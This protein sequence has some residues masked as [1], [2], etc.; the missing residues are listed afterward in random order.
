MVHG[1]I[2]LRSSL[3][4]SI[5]LFFTAF[6]ICAP[7]LA[8]TCT[9]D[10]LN[11]ILERNVLTVGLKADYKPWGFKSDEGEIIGM[12]ADLALE[13]ANTLGVA[14]QTVEVT[15][16]D[17]IQKLS[18][19]EIDLLIA[20]MSDRA[21]RRELVGIALPNYY[22][23]GTNVMTAQNTKISQWTELK[24]KKVCGKQGAFYNKMVQQRYGAE[25]LS[26]SSVE[27]AKHALRDNECVAWVYDDSSIMSDL[28]SG[29]WEGFKMPLISEDNNPWG[30]AVPLEDKDCILG[31]V[32][33]GLQFNW[34]AN[35]KLIEIEKKWGIQATEFLKTQHARF[36]DWLTD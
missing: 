25:I 14:L 35:G 10:T 16:A 8:A 7:S 22:T 21:D 12:E 4:S 3:F 33:S 29:D 24:D 11:R 15:S 17:R 2:R 9:N 5:I 1:R 13:I 6:V 31:Q 19:G 26:F 23:S 34:H 18:N 30:I 36:S 27:E 32:V 28:A 20:T